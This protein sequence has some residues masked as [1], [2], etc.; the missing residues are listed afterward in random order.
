[1]SI[2]LLVFFKKNFVIINYTYSSMMLIQLK[3]YVSTDIKYLSFR[4]DCIT[5]QALA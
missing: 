5:S 2:R 4:N 1:M 3:Q